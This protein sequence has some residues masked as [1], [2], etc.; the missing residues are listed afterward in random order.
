MPGIAG[1]LFAIP[2]GRLLQ[3]QKK[4]VPWFSGAR[5]SVIACYA[6]TGLA[7]FIVPER[8]LVTTILLIWAIATIPQ[9]VLSI[10]F[11][12]VMNAVAG[13]THR[14][15]LMTR[16]WS[17]L[18]LTS[19]IT[20]FAVGQIL[21]QTPYPLNYRLMFIILSIGGLISFYFSSHINLPDS[22]PPP[23]STG[24]SAREKF[25]ELIQLIRSQK[26]FVWFISRRL[27]Y[28]TGIS[29]SAPLF[30]LYF[31][32]EIKV[33]DSW[34]ANIAI[35]QTAVMI[36]GYFFWTNQ[37]RRKGSKTTLLWTTLGLSFYPLLTALTHQPWLI[38]LY[39]GMAGIFQAGLDLVFFDELMKTVPDR[40]SAT[41]VSFAQSAQYLSTIA[42]PLIGSLLA[43]WLGLSAA[44]IIAGS[45][46]LLGF[47]LFFTG[48]RKR[49]RNITN[50]PVS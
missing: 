8:F 20:I 4:I 1:L 27:V 36:I 24:H 39:A 42:S 12:V 3:N 30:P 32:R 26:E 14:F 49:S 50:L 44:L 31:V 33:S 21:D 46:R 11:S 40:Y 28:F 35:A 45:I 15:D 29:M 38:T 47:M 17:T 43:D 41:F 16:R 7:S 37:S 48:Y 10:S 23:Q 2:F 5:L 6:L 9:T 13:P 34:I 22:I 25:T 18:G 19:T